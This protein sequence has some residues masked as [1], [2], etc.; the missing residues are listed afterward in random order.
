LDVVIYILIAN[1]GHF[2]FLRVSVEFI[3]NVQDDSSDDERS[4]DSSSSAESDSE[5][6]QPL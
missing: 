4:S 1:I 6:A 5:L 3:V 2:G